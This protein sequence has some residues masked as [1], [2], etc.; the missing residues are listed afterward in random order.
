MENQNY[1]VFD[2][3]VENYRKSS[4]DD[5]EIQLTREEYRELI[6]MCCD[7]LEVLCHKASKE[8]ESRKI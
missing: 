4:V 8:V 5:N 2:K 6:L 1:I 7:F 3:I